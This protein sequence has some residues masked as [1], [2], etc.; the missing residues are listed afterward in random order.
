LQIRK[1]SDVRLAGLMRRARRNVTDLRIS[2][3]DDTLLFRGEM[4]GFDSSDNF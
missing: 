4:R 3:S 1:K 2:A